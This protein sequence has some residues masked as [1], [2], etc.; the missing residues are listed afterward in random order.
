[1]RIPVISHPALDYTKV[2]LLA[3][4]ER[5]R[6]RGTDR[7][8]SAVEWVIISAIIVA[9]VIVVGTLLYNALE[10]KAKDTGECITGS[11]HSNSGKCK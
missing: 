5:A 1:M 9:I 4:I 11:T 2:M 10:T 8:A 3:R 6:D 7:G